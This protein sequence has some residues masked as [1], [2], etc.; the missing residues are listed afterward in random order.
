MK[1]MKKMS[2]IISLAL[3]V[4]IGGVYAAWVYPGT[5]ASVATADKT[6]T[7]NMTTV[8]WADSKGAI[9]VDSAKDTLAFHIDDAGAYVPEVET[10]GNLEFYFDPAD[11]VSADIADNGIDMIIEV[12]VEGGKQAYEGVTIFTAKEDENTITIPKGSTVKQ[13][14]GTFRASISCAQIFECLTFLPDSTGVSNPNAIVLDTYQKNKAFEAALA[15]Y[16]I[17]L[18]ITEAPAQQG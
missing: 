13:A 9:H 2:L 12:T 4:T 3:I 1:F 17:T 7:G 15:T 8:E 5:D 6:L 11:G 10:S 16:I 18:T 14:D